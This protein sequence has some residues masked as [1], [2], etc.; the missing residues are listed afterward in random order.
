MNYSLMHKY[1]HNSI[2]PLFLAA[3]LILLHACKHEDELPTLPSLT[4][5]VAVVFEQPDMNTRSSEGESVI[6]D[7]WFFQF[8]Q[9]KR[10]VQAPVFYS[11]NS[12]SGHVPLMK[13]GEGNEYTCVFVVN[14]GKD[15]E[16]FKHLP[17]NIKAWKAFTLDNLT[18]AHC[19]FNNYYGEHP[20]LM[21]GEGVEK[22]NDQ[23][24]AVTDHTTTMTCEL[25][26]N[27]AKVV[28][29]VNLPLDHLNE[30]DTFELEEIRLENVPQHVRYYH[31][32]EEDARDS[33]YIET[34]SLI[35]FT[36]RD[37]EVTPQVL[38][39]PAKG[40]H[41]I[42]TLYLPSNPKGSDHKNYDPTRRKDEA[43]AGATDIRLRVNYRKSGEFHPVTYHIFV[44]CKITNQT[45]NYTDYNVLSNHCYNITATINGYNNHNTDSRIEFLYDIVTVYIGMEDYKHQWGQPG[46]NPV[47]DTGMDGHITYN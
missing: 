12:F 29:S 34:Q 7:F 6:H 19:T 13:M 5:E 27:T 24:R 25:K 21:S 28:L 40:G 45:P 43:P 23:T 39:H 22:E 1:N 46:Y 41:F 42:T 14:A 33:D 2:F 37:D 47:G 38:K 31:I 18:D 17:D 4:Q 16:A 35:R 32:D 15:A 9:D 36:N 30:G 3:L 20:M 10:L 11:I 8:D 26:H 44:G